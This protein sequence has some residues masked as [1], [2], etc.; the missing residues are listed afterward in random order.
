MSDGKKDAKKNILLRLKRI[1]GQVRGVQGMIESE[2]A[3]GEILNQVAAIKAA[4]NQ[5]GI[6][7]FENHARECILR[8]LS[9]EKQD[10]S[11]QQIVEMMGRLI[12]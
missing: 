2:A 11:F 5:V 6:L 7:M 10:E 9:E 12:K 8:A 1:E 3:C 4:M